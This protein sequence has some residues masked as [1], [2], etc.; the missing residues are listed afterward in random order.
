[1]SPSPVVTDRS[2]LML[3]I[4]LFLYLSTATSSISL[5]VDLSVPARAFSKNGNFLVNLTLSNTAGSNSIQAL[6]KFKSDTTFELP[7]QSGDTQQFLSFAPVQSSSSVHPVEIPLTTRPLIRPRPGDAVL[8]IHPRSDIT[9]HLGSL[10][11]IKQGNGIGELVLG[12]TMEAFIATCIPD[13]L[14]TF[15][16]SRDVVQVEI[17]T[18]VGYSRA[19]YSSRRLLLQFFSDEFM[20]TVPSHTYETIVNSLIER[21][22]VRARPHLYSGLYSDC[23]PD[24]LSELPTISFYLENLVTIVLSPEDYV[25]FTGVDNTCQLLIVAEGGDDYYFIDPLKI[26]HVNVRITNSD[27]LSICDSNAQ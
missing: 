8:G 9:Q 5:P 23:T 2:L 25:E 10:A 18:V 14:V 12:S 22:A 19:S 17:S 3:L 4:L 6:V 20:A 16:R 7:V 24:V 13:S 11:L 15:D 26:P 27:E 21:R 1:M